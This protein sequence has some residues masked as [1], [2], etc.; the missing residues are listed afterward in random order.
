MPLH[1]YKNDTRKI[2]WLDFHDQTDI[3]MYYHILYHDSYK[4]HFLFRRKYIQVVV[5][6][7]TDT[8]FYLSEPKLIVSSRD[9]EVSPLNKPGQKIVRKICVNIS[10]LGS[11]IRVVKKY[12]SML[13]LGGGGPKHEHY[14]LLRTGTS[15]I[16]ANL[17]ACHSSP[18]GGGGGAM[19]F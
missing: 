11:T 3:I 16:L 2:S 12:P 9:V 18:T 8:E 17:Q 4:L 5:H 15:T 6:G 10:K 7:S 1:T 13:V 19:E 14:P